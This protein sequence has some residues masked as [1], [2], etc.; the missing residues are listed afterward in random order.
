M[1]GDAIKLYRT[2]KN[3]SEKYLASKLKISQSYYS[4]IER[5]S[6]KPN[7]EQLKKLAA[8]FDINEE[9]LQSFNNGTQPIINIDKIVSL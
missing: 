4:R 5:N 9:T 7:T 8:E 3:L 2:Q 1:L 6:A